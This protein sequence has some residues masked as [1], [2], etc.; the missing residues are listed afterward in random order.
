MLYN[1]VQV[2]TMLIALLLVCALMIARCPDG[3]LWLEGETQRVRS[4]ALPDLR[5]ETQ[6]C[7]AYTSAWTWPRVFTSL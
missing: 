7:E 4:T 1:F 2:A 6:P 3:R 5:R